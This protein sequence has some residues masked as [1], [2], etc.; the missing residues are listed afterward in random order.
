VIESVV[1]DQVSYVTVFRTRPKGDFIVQPYRLRRGSAST[2]DARG[3]ARVLIQ[4][5]DYV[6]TIAQVVLDGLD[7]FFERVDEADF[8]RTPDPPLQSLAASVVLEGPLLRL[9]TM[10]RLHGGHAGTGEHWQLERSEA[11]A[12]LPALLLEALGE[13]PED[14][15]RLLA[16]LQSRGKARG[17]P[18]RS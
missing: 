1:P 6:S 4:K 15:P 7:R 11:N 17:R 5:S 12:R 10:R 3:V 9:G 8:D 18:T 2:T 13:R 16:R 14:V